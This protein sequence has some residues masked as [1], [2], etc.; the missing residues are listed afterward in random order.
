[1]T[2]MVMIDSCGSEG[3][4]NLKL[5]ITVNSG[6]LFVLPNVPSLIP[7]LKRGI[8]VHNEVEVTIVVDLE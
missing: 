4:E 1:M 6:K 5:E 7:K 2:V 8:G 3:A